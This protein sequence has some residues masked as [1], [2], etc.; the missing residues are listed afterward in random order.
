MGENVIHVW[1]HQEG[2]WVLE[3]LPVALVIA[4]SCQC[5]GT[6][7]TMLSDIWPDFWVVLFGARSQPWW[8]LWLPSDL[9]YSTI[10][11][12]YGSQG[13]VLQSHWRIL[14]FVFCRY[15]K[16]CKSFTLFTIAT[17]TLN[18]CK[19]LLLST[20][21]RLTDTNKQNFTPQLGGRE[22]KLF[23]VVSYFHFV[24][25]CLLKTSTPKPRQNPRHT[26]FHS[27]KYW[28]LL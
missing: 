1:I 9:G 26:P 15:L 24:W 25:V 21:K 18:I 10:L 28:A 22:V 17:L 6:F 5:S 7:W 14:P 23:C 20:A 3:R 11:W 4:P 19:V 12:F 27:N 8:S 2:G 13:I 16:M